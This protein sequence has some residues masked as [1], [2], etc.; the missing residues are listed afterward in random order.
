VNGRLFLPIHRVS[1]E[2]CGS[3]G[4]GEGLEDGEAVATATLGYDTR[5]GAFALEEVRDVEV[6]A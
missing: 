6:S 5:V 3:P 2:A 4:D 1:C